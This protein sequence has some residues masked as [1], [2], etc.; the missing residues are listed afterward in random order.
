MDAQQLAQ[1]YE[2]ATLEAEAGN[3][4]TA[5]EQF[6]MYLKHCPHDGKA[7][8]DA[9]TLLFCLGRY[10]ESLEFY[11]RAAKLCTGEALGQVY[12]NLCEVYLHQQMP[13]EIVPFLDVME[14]L[15][16]L[17]PDL[18][19]RAASQLIEQGGLIL[20]SQMLWRS[21]RLNPNQDVLKPM[22]EV[23]RNKQLPVDC[24]TAYEAVLWQ[25]LKYGLS[26][27]MPLNWNDVSSAQSAEKTA[28]A[29]VFL[30]IS[31]RLV[32]ASQSSEHSAMVAILMPQ[33]MYHPLLEQVRWNALGTVILCGADTVKQMFFDRIGRMSFMPRWLSASPVPDVSF[34]PFTSRRPGKKIAAYGRWSARTNPVFLLMCFQ[35]LHYLDPDMRLYVAGEFE[36]TATQ[37]QIEHLIQTMALENAVFFDGAIKDFGK[38][39]RDKHYFVNVSLDGEGVDMAWF[40]AAMGICPLMHTFPAVNDVAEPTMVFTLAEDFCRLVQN[41]DYQSDQFRAAAARR[42]SENGLQK[43]LVEVLGRIEL[44]HSKQQTATTQNAQ[45]LSVV[46]P[47][48]TLPLTSPSTSPATQDVSQSIQQLR[49]LAEQMKQRGAIQET[50]HSSSVLSTDSPEAAGGIQDVPFMWSNAVGR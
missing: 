39:L 17:S 49:S 20:A 27:L 25:D 29:K 14:K 47:S 2:Q 38:W 32:Q 28:I 42:Y 11:H 40:A 36:D 45:S 50:S 34:I 7:F 15:D 35:K 13:A 43:V 22:L 19:N 12:W 41:A 18:L 24:W 33:D 26:D 3:H 4:Q 31:E 6:E 37:A 5:L 46:S 44:R 16:I 30:G 23:I 8:N 48:T 9:A 1:L 21:L 10:E